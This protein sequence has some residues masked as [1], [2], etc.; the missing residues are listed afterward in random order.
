MAKNRDE[1]NDDGWTEEKLAAWQRAADRFRARGAAA[2]AMDFPAML[3]DMVPE[4][5]PSAENN[6]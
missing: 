4:D 2:D 3:E 6:E 1:Q 5:Y